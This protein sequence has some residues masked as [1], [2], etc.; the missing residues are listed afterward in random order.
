MQKIIYFVLITIGFSLNAHAEFEWQKQ[1]P[2]ELTGQQMN[3]FFNS[4]QIRA[5]K[6][7]AHDC[8]FTN[9]YDSAKGTVNIVFSQAQTRSK[10]AV[11]FSKLVQVEAEEGDLGAFITYGIR[12]SENGPVDTKGS[13]KTVFY[14]TINAES[15]V[16]HDVMFKSEVA[17]RYDVVDGKWHY[18]E[19]YKDINGNPLPSMRCHF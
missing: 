9:S 14:L 2:S 5:G 8:T 15:R 13:T 17:S 12:I 4:E 16:L 6:F 19:A 1:W 10:Q 3:E 18:E 7:V 11:S